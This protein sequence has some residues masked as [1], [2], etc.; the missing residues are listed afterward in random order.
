MINES[1]KSVV[2]LLIFTVIILLNCSHNPS[3]PEIIEE[4]KLAVFCILDPTSSAQTILLQRTL[5]FSEVSPQYSRELAVS[6]AEIVLTGPDGE[7]ETHSMPN[8]SQTVE[9]QKVLFPSDFLGGG[10]DFNYFLSGCP[11]QT[12][13]LYRLSISSEEYGTIHA[14]ATVPEPF[15]ITQCGFIYEKFSGKFSAQW[16]ESPGA[17]G[18]LVDLTVLEYDLSYQWYFEPPFGETSAYGQPILIDVSKIPYREIP[19]NLSRK[20]TDFQR[21]FLTHEKK[22]E[23]PTHIL[24]EIFPDPPSG[25]K[26]YYKKHIRLI[27]VHVHAL[28]RHLYDFIAYQYTRN[29]TI[30]Q[31]S[32][33]QDISNIDG[34]IGIFGA[35]YTMTMTSQLNNYLSGGIEHGSVPGGYFQEP[36]SHLQPEDGTN[37]TPE[38]NVMLTWSPITGAEHYLLV[39]KPRYLWFDTGGYSI[40]LDDNQFEISWGDFPYRDC[41][42][43]WY[44]KGIQKNLNK[45]VDSLSICLAAPDKGSLVINCA[46]VIHWEDLIWPEADQTGH[47]VFTSR[48][49]DSPWSESRFLRTLSGDLPGF[50]MSRPQII[51]PEQGAVIS[52]T[53]KLKWKGVNGAEI[54]L[55]YMYTENDYALAVT[56]DV[57][58]SPPFQDEN[59]VVEGLRVLEKFERG[60][61]YTWQVCALRVKSGAP[62]FVVGEQKGEIPLKIY[63]R[64]QHPSGIMLQSQWSGAQR[65]TV[66]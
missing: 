11:V 23:I 36:P 45:Y 51:E 18:Y 2:L 37:L 24:Y 48:S 53:G 41:E 19:L 38:K 62:G 59:S 47:G 15:E 39:L 46:Y 13:K 7:F 35:A 29:Q 16:T 10:E 28:N 43:E 57:E 20:E 33:L 61:S 8:T 6:D 5:G 22:L 9:E 63:P 65:F 26:D 30:G 17:V 12:G 4:K 50:E 56:G 32:V 52:E 34:G 1:H 27:C 42:I 60:A 14:E 40:L 54:Y 25:E 58:I 49:N 3:G 44:V 66:N 55:I 21:G 31:E 64:Y